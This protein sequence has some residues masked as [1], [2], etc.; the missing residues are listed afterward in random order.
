MV[1]RSDSRQ[2]GLTD[3]Y[4]NRSLAYLDNGQ[5]ERAIQD[6]DQAITLDSSLINGYYARGSAYTNLGECIRALADLDE[7]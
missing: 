4:Y 1:R 7:P 5:Y 6:L 3:A 2:P